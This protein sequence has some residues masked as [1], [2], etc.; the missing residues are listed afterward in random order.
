M[1]IL[2]KTRAIS[3]AVLVSA[4]SCYAAQ[5][6]EEVIVTSDFR[7]SQLQT[8]PASLSV[9]TEEV[10]Q[11]RAAQH[12][13]DII[14]LAPN[15]NYASG[16]SRARYF[17][18]RG[19]GE[20]SQF[21]QPISPSVGFLIDEIDFSGIG[22]A[23]TMF[24]VAQVEVL[25]GPQGTRYGAN[26]LAG[27]INVRTKPPTEQLDA[28][29]EATIA[30]YDTYS[31]AAAVSG[32]LVENIL[33]GRIAVQ[34]YKSDGFID[35]T[36]LGRDDTNNRDEQTVRAKLRWLA[37]EDIT[38]DFTALYVDIDNGYDAFS[39]DNDRK[40]RSDDP[41]QDTQRTSALGVK[42]DW[43]VSDVLRLEALASY[44]ESDL[45]YNYDEDWTYVGFT[46]DICQLDS[47]DF[48]FCEYSSTDSYDRDRDN[49]SAEVRLLSD[50]AG[51]I[52]NGS[53][54]WVVGVYHAA[55]NEDL[56]RES[57]YDGILN[58]EYETENT[59][60]YGQLDI[61]L[62]DKLSLITGLRFEQWEA[63]YADSTNL[64]IDTNEDLWG[65][66]IALDYQVN[67]Q[68]LVYGSF[69]RGYK[70]GGVNTDG[71]LPD[72]E[73]S[74]DTEYLWNL[75]GGIKSLWLDNTLSSRIAVFYAQREDQQVTGSFV[76]P[77]VPGPGDD[78]IDYIDNAGE[79][80]N[81]GVEVE[82]DW[83]FNEQLQLFANVGILETEIDEYITTSNGEDKSGRDQAHAPDYQFA[84]GGEYAIN[85]SWYIRG[86]VEG[87]DKFYFSDRHDE[88]S[89]AYELLSARIG[90]RADK[91][92]VALWGRNL[93]DEDYQNRGFGFLNDPRDNYS[94]GG[95]YQLGEPR[96]VGFTLGWNL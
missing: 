27:L 12:I 34:Q 94:T 32:P 69:S 63:D 24:D 42:L 53:T 35:N 68:H 65:G 71:S 19:I 92:S 44:A 91:W 1:K 59:A 11:A 40:T 2:F 89:E 96:M 17:Q 49:Y 86:E 45:E 61:A 13:E 85:Q 74:F 72:D 57:T 82:L 47:E 52:F 4:S 80:E 33:L 37:S 55:K 10:I 14:N 28:S 46:D 22:T 81:Y 21:A 90:Y 93:L 7:S 95:Y 41:G 60:I 87:K 56:F 66:K 76:I 6:I 79:G 29:V 16:S 83:Q 3:L 43:G 30:D 62:T 70:A 48:L 9:V 67:D 73:R 84:V 18:I 64:L 31:L 75:E 26:A 25:R 20:R 5:T 78:F 15:V 77:R 88:Q 38:I 51:K 54:D 36:Y 50:E 58:S 23:A 39:L 8:I